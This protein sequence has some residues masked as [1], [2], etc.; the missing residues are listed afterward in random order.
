MLLD[1]SRER[2]VGARVEHEENDTGGLCIEPL[3]NPKSPAV[4]SSSLWSELLFD[5][6]DQAR[7]SR[8]GRRHGRQSGGLVDGQEHAIVEKD[9]HCRRGLALR[10]GTAAAGFDL[11]SRAQN[12]TGPSHDDTIDPR[13]PSH[14]D[15][16]GLR[17]AERVRGRGKGEAVEYEVD[18]PPTTLTARHFPSTKGGRAGPGRRSHGAHVA[19]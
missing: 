15:S 6:G 10:A 2:R 18:Q 14:D 9:A 3:V 17:A 5:Q 19:T 16:A 12:E 4:S 8:V 11:H 1:L 13:S 7:P